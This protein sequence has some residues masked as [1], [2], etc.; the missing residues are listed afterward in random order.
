M[1]T[2]GLWS[3]TWQ[4]DAPKGRVGGDR[5][6]YIRARDEG[7]RG[8]GGSNL[9]VSTAGG[10]RLELPASA[11]SNARAQGS[12]HG[13]RQGHEHAHACPHI[14]LPSGAW[15]FPLPLPT[16]AV[17]RELEPTVPP[18]ERQDRD[19]GESLAGVMDAT[20]PR[21]RLV[22]GRVALAVARLA[23]RSVVGAAVLSVVLAGW[24]ALQRAPSRSRACAARFLPCVLSSP[25]EG[26]EGWRDLPARRPLGLSPARVGRLA[27]MARQLVASRLVFVSLRQCS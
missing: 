19:A 20:G 4:P 1:P 8:G 17:S 11:R 21:P 23:V 27:R 24:F 16:C 10:G 3:A 5:I 13:H 7:Q 15:P 2:P 18:F 12:R 14:S 25:L 9:T 22:S 26:W 6:P